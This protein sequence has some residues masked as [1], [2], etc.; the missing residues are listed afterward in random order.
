MLKIPAGIPSFL[1]HRP[2][3]GLGKEEPWSARAGAKGRVRRECMDRAVLGSVIYQKTL[4]SLFLKSSWP[5]SLHTTHSGPRLPRVGWV[6][7]SPEHD[8]PTRTGQ[9]PGP[10]LPY[11]L[12]CFHSP[13]KWATRGGAGCKSFLIFCCCCYGTKGRKIT[14]K[15]IPQGQGGGGSQH[16]MLDA[17]PV[18]T[19]SRPRRA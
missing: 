8:V 19:A 18:P 10:P 6:V 5:F 17:H 7:P 13:G 3:L 9:D 15:K 14:K 2:G 11:P 12:P 1:P 16:I 4:P